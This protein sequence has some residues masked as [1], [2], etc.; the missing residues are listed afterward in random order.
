[1]KHPFFCASLLLIYLFL[2][3]GQA[4]AGGGKNPLNIKEAIAL[5]LANNSTLLSFREEASK[6]YAFKIQADGTLTP[7]ITLSGSFDTQKEKQTDDGSDRYDSRSAAVT[8][9]QTLYSGGRNQALRRQSSQVRAIAQLNLEDAE[10]RAIGELFARFYN[11]I[12]QERYV[13][14]ERAAIAAGELHLREVTRMSELGLSNRLEVIR[15]SQQLSA[16]KADLVSAEGLYDSAVISLMNFLAVPP[17]ERRPVTG[18]LDS[19]DIAPM[20]AAGVK[21][22][23]LKTAMNNRADLAA[24]KQQI[25]YQGNQIEIE[26]SALRPQVSFGA[27]A[28]LSNPYNRRNRGDDTWRAELM[29]TLPIFDRNTTRGNVINAQTV[30]KQDQIAH[31]QKELDVK[32]ET[33]TAWTEL[34]TAQ[35]RLEATAQT[36]ELAEETLRL[37]EVGFEEGVTPQLDLLSARVSLT[38]SQL[39]YLRALYNNLL[40]IVALKVTEG[41]IVSWA[42]EVKF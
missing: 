33:E 22:E 11:V 18:S 29:L 26:R 39:E 25:D 19:M 24:L 5:T 42:E 35:E 30:M 40:A 4:S 7:Q 9:S 1:M 15:A 34:E 41:N 21:E 3:L 16:D 2:N 27:S 12:L 14:T 23:S 20:D 17:E 31:V 38:E 13:E 8:L 37:A 6:A 36:L 28:G 10:N 32:S